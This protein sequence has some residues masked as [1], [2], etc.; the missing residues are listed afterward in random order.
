MSKTYILILSL[1]LS[2]FLFG[3]D[4]DRGIK[5]LSF[6]EKRYMNTFFDKAIKNDQAGHVLCFKT[7]PVALIAIVLKSRGKTIKEEMKAL[8]GWKAFKR[9]QD[10]FPHSNFIFTENYFNP[11]KDLS[12]L[13]VYMINK[14]SLKSCLEK[15]KQ[16]FEEILGKGFSAKKFIS[17]IEQGSSLP[18]LTKNDPLLMGLLLGYGE[19]SSKAFKSLET[20][21]PQ[22]LQS[23][24]IN[25]PKECDFMPVMF[26]GNPNSE[27][28]K[29]LVSTYEQELGEI[30]SIYKNSKK[31]LK[32]VL[33]KL[34]SN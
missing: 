24:S 18:S 28:V 8:K 23:I 11:D 33:E 22:T 5:K 20:Q 17:Q 1:A 30:W 31:P 19:E 4:V 12:V 27:E 14:K 6:L 32:T 3:N 34:C 13:H 16:N 7:K 10:L 25:K 9:H 29:E 21:S 15:Y 26:G 2:S